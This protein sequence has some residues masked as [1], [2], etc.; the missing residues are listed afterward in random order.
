MKALDGAIRTKLAADT[1]AGGVNTLATGGI[2][3]MVNPTDPPSYPFVVFQLMTSEDY[4]TLSGRNHERPLMLVKAIDH[5]PDPAPALAL[6]DRI[7]AVLTDGSITGAGITVKY[8]RRVSR[9]EYIDQDGDQF[10]QHCG[11]M[12]QLMTEAA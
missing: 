5:N 9:I 7:D 3:R 8:C 12:F 4:Y 2:W 6:A 10:Y 11:G 1:G